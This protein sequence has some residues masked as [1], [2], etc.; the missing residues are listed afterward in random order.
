VF[1][2]GFDLPAVE[3]ICAGPPLEEADVFEVVASLVDKSM[4]VADRGD[5]G[6]RYRLLATLRQFAAECVAEAGDGDGLQERHLHHYLAVAQE[7]SRLWASPRQ[8]TG[9]GIFEREWDNLRAA[10]AWA[11]ASA[12]VHGADLIVEATGRH[13][14]PRGRQEHGDWAQRT[15]ELESIGLHPASTTYSWAAVAAVYADDN[16]V[17]IK[18]AERGI[19]AAPWPDHP[20]TAGCW[21]WLIM[22]HL[23]SGRG[24][25]A[26]EPARHLAMIEPALADPV[27]DWH[28][29]D[30][31]FQNAL[32]NDRGSVPALVDRLAERAGQIGAPYL[33]SQT[34]Y[35]RA[36]SAL[37]A[38][39]PRDPE[40]AFTA[41]SEG[42]ALARSAGDP[43]PEGNNLST[44]AFA[45]VALRRSDAGEICRDAV[46]RLYDLRYW[47]TLWMLIETVAHFLAAAGSLEEAAVLY[48]HLEAQHSPWA[49]PAVGRARQRGLDRV[50]Q[51]A[52]CDLLMARGAAMNREELVA[53]T[54]DRL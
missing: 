30:G 17:G 49:I 11:V 3:A 14:Q 45:A 18:L 5:T 22:G 26:V 36:V 25:A 41:A 24:G 32:A 4:V 54:L 47:P 31:L 40:R 23:A 43:G 20:D 2:G 37:Y 42:L 35:R 39:D 21:V 48:G 34:A 13:S 6:T 9:D 8:L 51:L 27:S 16:E 38:E 10:H 12:N 1:A 53:Y 19:H 33:F 50:R 7:A 46:T 44:L 28:A 52:E 29:L 15:L